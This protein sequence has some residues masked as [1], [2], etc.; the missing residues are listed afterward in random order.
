MGEARRASVMHPR[1]KIVDIAKGI[2]ILLVLFG[3]MIPY[4][5]FTGQLIYS[6][7]MPLFLFLAGLYVCVRTPGETMR[8]VVERMAVPY[9]MFLMIGGLLYFTRTGIST[10]TL[11]DMKHILRSWIYTCDPIGNGNLW[12]LAALAGGTLILRVVLPKLEQGNAIV[13]GSL[14][15]VF[16]FLFTFL[17]LIRI[18]PKDVPFHM[19]KWLMVSVFMYAGFTFRRIV[20]RD[21]GMVKR[22]VIILLAIMVL[23]VITEI[24]SQNKIHMFRPAVFISAPIGIAMVISTAK[25]LGNIPFVSAT[26]AF[27]GK[28]SLVLFGLDSSI[29]PWL[30]LLLNR[31]GL[32]FSIAPDRTLVANGRADWQIILVLL[33]AE[34]V[35][36]SALVPLM[37]RLLQMG[38]EAFCDMAG[39]NSLRT[40]SC[41]VGRIDERQ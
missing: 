28:N 24:D 36:L 20:E 34:T 11:P 23:P 5:S 32:S 7:H 30:V 1:N 25:I 10:V 6:F 14:Y 18:M 21:W 41:G 37:N 13:R 16:A 4:H 2:G 8:R 29:R 35:V 39:A 22:A 26:L 9:A 15:C 38:R 40:L 27:F 3:H 17:V 33:V 12:F 19:D 31:I